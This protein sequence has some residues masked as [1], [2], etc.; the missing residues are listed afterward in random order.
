MLNHGYLCFIA[1]K[2]SGGRMVDVFH[3]WFKETEKLAYCFW[4]KACSSSIGNTF[5]SSHQQLGMLLKK[6]F[7]PFL[8]SLLTGFRR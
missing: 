7:K 8:P 3:S 1:V 2:Q 5:K 4:S 6:T